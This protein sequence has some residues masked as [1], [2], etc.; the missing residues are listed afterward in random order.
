[1]LFACLLGFGEAVPLGFQGRNDVR[2]V[3]HQ[4]TSTWLTPFSL[5]TLSTW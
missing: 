4:A 2:Q 5:L 1:M 3:Q